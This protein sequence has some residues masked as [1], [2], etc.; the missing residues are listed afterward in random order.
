M[1]VFDV[2]KKWVILAP[3][4]CRAASLD[5]LAAA[6]A[7]LRRNAGL[8]DAAPGIIDAE[9]AAAGSGAE[10]LVN[11]DAGSD[12][13]NYAWRA[14][15]DRVE[16][17][18]HSLRS[19][20]NAIFDFLAALGIDAPLCGGVRLP[21]PQAAAAYPLRKT[22]VYTHQRARREVR[23]IPGS[24][25]FEEVRA[26]VLWAGK[27]AVDEIILSLAPAYPAARN[28]EI[29]R[30]ARSYHLA[31]AR[32][33]FELSLLVP[34]KLFLF[35]KELFRMEGGKRLKD[36][37]FCASNHKTQEIIRENAARFFTRYAGTK[38]YYLF[39]DTAHG[40]DSWC[41]C[42]AC[43]AFSFEEQKIMALRAAAAALAG[44]DSTARIYWPQGAQEKSTVQP[45]ANM[46]A[47]ETANLEIL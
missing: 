17:Y 23:L 45:A 43:R 44:V 27:N 8:D 38:N 35:H 14:A 20:D 22:S 5:D 40:A 24:L 12:K 19:V 31:V 4:L 9:A 11:A 30:L 47:A 21:R 34:R 36:A 10:L 41:S 42:P 26:R 39:P 32:G 13:N 2:S 46:Q 18:G 28:Q 15:G 25:S 33:G 6:I 37:H 3:Q 7:L 16:I 1:G 29:E